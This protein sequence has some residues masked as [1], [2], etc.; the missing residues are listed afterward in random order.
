V[1]R[2]RPLL[3]FL[4][5][6]ALIVSAII[7]ITRT[8]AERAARSE[9]LRIAER[10]TEV[11]ANSV[12]QPLITPTLLRGTERS[13]REFDLIMLDRVLIDDVRRIKIWSADGRIVYSD[14]NQL[15]G[16]SFELEQSQK[17]ILNNGGT[18]ATLTDLT[19]SEN[20]L[21]PE[22][23][24]LVEVYTRIKTSD[25]VPLLF[26]IYYSKEELQKQQETVIRP[27]ERII[28]GGQLALGATAVFMLWGASRRLRV[29]ADA[30]ERLLHTA[31]HSSNNERRRIARDLHDGVV[32]DLAGSAFSIQAIANVMEAGAL[33][34]QLE[35][36]GRSLRKGLA[37]LRSLLVEIYPPDLS[38]E[39]VE[40]ALRDLTAQAD[41][42]QMQV[43]LAVEEL[44]GVSR[45]TL[46]LVWRV[47]QEGI[48]NAIR[49]SGANNLWV[50]VASSGN[51]VLLTVRDNGRGI[52]DNAGAVTEGGFG[53]TGLRSLVD[54]AG[55]SLLV[56]STPTAGTTLE[57]KVAK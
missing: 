51:W 37:A 18:Y 47:A 12:A 21:D 30:R 10:T 41:R 4:F 26:E 15:I 53:L 11:L 7:Y 40:S 2:L 28:V 16:Q 22:E 38:A 17:T 57:L 23:A 35:Q 54:D 29:A 45:N 3:I 34:E 50:S 20:E 44:S 56:S 27:F 19:K 48:R 25:Q 31:V 39:N 36:A 5:L 52:D 55:G 1:N 14:E 32:Q 8:F 46:E 49:H 9:A 33:R 24:G 6:G 13:L 42:S 43:E